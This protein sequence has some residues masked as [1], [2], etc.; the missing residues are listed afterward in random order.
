MGQMV[1]VPRGNWKTVG[2]KSPV[3]TLGGGKEEDLPDGSR[4]S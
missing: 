2:K 1:S 3:S 4:P